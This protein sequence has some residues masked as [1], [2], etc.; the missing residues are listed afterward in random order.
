[1]V[2]MVPSMGENRAA[3]S[4][5]LRDALFQRRIKPE[6]YA[7]Y[8]DRVRGYAEEILQN[9]ARRFGYSRESALDTVLFALRK[10]IIDFGEII[11]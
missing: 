7:T 3:V 10:R 2:V 11:S 5:Q 1:M 6:K 9:M 4:C 8:D